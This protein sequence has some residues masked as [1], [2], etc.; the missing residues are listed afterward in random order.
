MYVYNVHACCPWRSE[1]SIGSPWN[2]SKP[3]CGCWEL[4]LGPLQEQQMLLTAKPAF[5]P[6]LFLYFG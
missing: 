1:E 3:P 5:F 6:V 4:N 2:W